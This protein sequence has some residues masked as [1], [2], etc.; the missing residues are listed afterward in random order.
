[1][2]H[3]GHASDLH[4]FLTG[5]VSGL[6]AFQIF[7]KT[8]WPRPWR[9]SFLSPVQLFGGFHAAEYSGFTGERSQK[10]GYISSRED[11]LTQFAYKTDCC[12][13]LLVGHCSGSGWFLTAH[14]RSSAW[15]PAL[16]AAG[17]EVGRSCGSAWHGVALR[18]SR[19]RSRCRARHSCVPMAALQGPLLVQPLPERCLGMVGAGRAA[20]ARKWRRNIRGRNRVT[21]RALLTSLCWNSPDCTLQ[22]PLRLWQA[23]A[24]RG[25]VRM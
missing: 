1:M 5:T 7:S 18:W 3:V 12:K 11:E 15:G 25:L 23:G 16:H 21:K 6:V 22:P 13:S 10:S 8:S 4:V 19:G 17:C 2:H 20:C 24:G 9:R 14:I